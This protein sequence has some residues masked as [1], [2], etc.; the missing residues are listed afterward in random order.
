MIR[1]HFVG[2]FWNH[3]QLQGKPEYLFWLP[4]SSCVDFQFNHALIILPM[5]FNARLILQKDIAGR[6]LIRVDIKAAMRQDKPCF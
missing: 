4:D 3:I 1:I 2:K 6:G 5:A